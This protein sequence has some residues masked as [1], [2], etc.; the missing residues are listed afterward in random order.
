VENSF[1]IDFVKSLCPGFKI[2][3]RAKLS[4]TLLNQE[5][6]FILTA[7]DDDLQNEKYLT[8]GKY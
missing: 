2:P 5:L 4:T 3:G 6:A 8:L 1:F 7:I